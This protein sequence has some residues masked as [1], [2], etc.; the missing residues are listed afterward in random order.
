MMVAGRGV[1]RN[2]PGSGRGV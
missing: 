2:D 1:T